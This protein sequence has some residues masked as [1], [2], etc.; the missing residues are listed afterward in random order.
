MLK[1]IKQAFI[2]LLSF[3]DLHMKSLTIQSVYLKTINHA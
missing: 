2:A 1:F 3:S